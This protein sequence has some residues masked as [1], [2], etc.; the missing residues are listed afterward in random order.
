METECA[1]FEIIR[2]A[3]L[4]MVSR[5]GY[6]KWR[7][8]RVCSE[9]TPTAQRRIDLEVKIFTHH[10]ESDR[11][12]GSPRITADLHEAGTLVSMNTVAS[13]MAS[14]GIAG[15]SPRTFK[16]VTTIADHEAQPEF[17][18]SSQHLLVGVRVYAR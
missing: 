11:T 13:I 9:L 5:A 4:L 8:A 7:Q 10:K 2:M 6:Y 12:Y 18:R 17:N 16:I 1:T 14:L 3:R 15:I